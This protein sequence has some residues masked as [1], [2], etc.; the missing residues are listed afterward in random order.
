MYTV[1]LCSF[2]CIKC[3]HPFKIP[4]LQCRYHYASLI[5]VLCPEGYNIHQY[6]DSTICLK[7]VTKGANYPDAVN[8][9]KGDGGDL[10]R[11]DSK[12][13]YDIFKAYLGIFFNLDQL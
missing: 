7:Y 3:K 10:I 11:M 1:I 6:T 2:T 13:K 9:C 12:Q 8:N 4:S 5:P